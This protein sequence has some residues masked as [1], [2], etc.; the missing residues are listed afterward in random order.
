MPEHTNP[1]PLATVGGAAL[2]AGL[3]IVA[4]VVWSC[5]AVVPPGHRGVRVTMGKV[6]PAALGEGIAFKL[7]LGLSQIE[8]MDVKQ[9]T[10]DGKTPCFSS[11]L[12]TVEIEYAVMYKVV[13]ERVVD[14]YQNHRGDPYDALVKPRLTEAL[15]QSTAA[16]TAE[17]L[18]QKR[19]VVREETRNRVRQAVGANIEIL[20]FNVTNIDLSNEMERAIESKMVQQQEALKKEFELNTEKKEAE[21][22]RVRAQ[23]EAEAVRVRAEAYSTNPVVLQMEIVKKWNGVSPNVVVTGGGANGTGE[24][25]GSQ[26]ILPLSI[27]A[28]P[29]TTPTP[30]R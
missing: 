13:P 2:M 5:F 22:V 29:R 17:Q 26:I 16:F 25:N 12:Q 11:D 24:S 27:P 15:K 28:A 10:A 19:E 21:I 30:N 7:P 23:A 8:E 20:D 1:N 18:V 6:S 14:L 9:Q 3:V 4:L